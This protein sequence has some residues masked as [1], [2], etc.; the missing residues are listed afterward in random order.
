M[1]S[2]DKLILKIEDLV[3]NE[4][5]EQLETEKIEFKD[6]SSSSSQWTE[7]YKT[8]C[9]FLNTNGGIIFLG[10]KESIDKKKLSIS[11]YQD[12]QEDKLKTIRHQFHNQDGVKVDLDSY[13]KFQTREIHDKP[14][15]LLFVE[16]LPEEEKYVFFKENAYERKLTGDHKISPNKIEIHN[17][18][19]IELENS[20]EIMPVI[21]AS[22]SDLDIDKLNEYITILNREIKTE[23]LK[24]DIESAKYFLNRKTFIRD[25]EP[26]VL[27]MLVC[28]NHVDDFLGSKCQ[29]DCYVE[30]DNSRIALDKQVIKDNILNLMERS[31]SFIVRNIKVAITTEDAGS[32]EPEYPEKLIRESVNNSLAH[33]D[34]RQN[35][36]INI[37]IVPARSIEIRNPG[38]F[39]KK[40]LIERIEAKNPIRRIIPGNPKA[41]NPKLAEVLKVFD[42]WEGKGYGMATLTNACLDNKIDL[43][44]YK[45]HSEEELS[46]IIPKGN[47]LD[48]KMETIFDTY[49]KYISEKMNGRNITHEQKTVISYFYKSEI[50]NRTDNYTILLTKDNNHSEAIGSLEKYEL[51]Y[52]DELSDAIN[53]IY[54]VDQLL[55]KTDFY[56]ELKIFFGSEF[57]LLKEEHKQVLQ[58]IYRRNHFSL[59]ETPSANQIGDA[60]WIEMGNANIIKGY[61]G[62]KRS[63]RNS[64]NQ[65]LKKGFIVRVDNKPKYRINE[66]FQK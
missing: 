52:R 66:G 26:T 16:S 62:F 53:T 3:R 58:N 2:V 63:N 43:P 44:Y 64:V 33:R 35:K 30:S 29:T 48:E 40:L 10:V 13:F 7:V 18:Y 37:N 46:L 54:R 11:G 31:I 22:I 65:L 19:K 14:V 15:L 5:Y 45:F 1:K 38:S 39:K 36:Y 25:N 24:P 32:S 49:G 34:Y 28:G 27:G 20:R 8:A 12:S 42:K 59:I 41:Q 23:S 4:E 17:E 50:R 57:S 21:G 61:D 9:A 47:L 6:N 60:I 51:I 56:D 55:F